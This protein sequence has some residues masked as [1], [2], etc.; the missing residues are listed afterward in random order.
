[1]EKS[2]KHTLI[3]IRRVPMKSKTVLAGVILE[4]FFA[5]FKDSMAVFNAEI[6]SSLP[7]GRWDLASMVETR[8]SRERTVWLEGCEEGPEP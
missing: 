2:R 3:I 1:M 8:G 6:A 5:S 4:I 7:L